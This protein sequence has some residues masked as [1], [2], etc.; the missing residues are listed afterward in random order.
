MMDENE[1]VIEFTERLHSKSDP[2][3]NES[4]IKIVNSTIAFVASYALIYI[5]FYFVTAL[6]AKRNHL[7]VKF[8]FFKV[9]YTSDYNAWIP[10][11]VVK[12]FIS[13]PLF[14][15]IVGISA[16]II[17]K[18]F[19]KK[20]GIFKLFLLWLGI[21]GINFFCTQ[22]ALLPIKNVGKSDQYASH[23][24]VVFD[25]LYLQND[26]LKLV[27]SIVSL[28]SLIIVGAVVAKP[29]IQITNSTRHVYKNEHRFVYLFQ[30]VLLPY[31]IGSIIILIYF[32]DGEFIMNLTTIFSL[33]VLIVSVFI[34]GL[35][36]RMIMIY[37]FPEQI[38]IEKKFLIILSSL[39]ILIKVFFN[40][41]ISF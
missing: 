22:M 38:E 41:G 24:G 34:N 20:P 8:F 37:R 1:Q 29:F 18:F 13:G 3:Q 39:M 26:L 10:D 4:T 7:F 9:E 40:D 11:P 32:S 25:Y 14:C 23:M 33:F 35:G 21:N 6:F 27:L 31:L 30:M 2:R 16:L 12:T 15:I 17:Q 36:S 5:L 19:K 28:I